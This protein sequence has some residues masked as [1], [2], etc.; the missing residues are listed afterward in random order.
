MGCVN[1]SLVEGNIVGGFK[2]MHQGPTTGCVNTS[3]VEGNIVG[4]FKVMH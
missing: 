3:L 4:G 2:V 1:T